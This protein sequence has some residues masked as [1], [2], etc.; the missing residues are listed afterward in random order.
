MAAEVLAESK[1]SLKILEKNLLCG[2][3]TEEL[4]LLK[5]LMAGEI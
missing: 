3:A 2:D 4:L 1:E 5:V